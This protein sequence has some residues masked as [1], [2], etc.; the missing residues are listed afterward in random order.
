MLNSIEFSP[1]VTRLRYNSI[2]RWVQVPRA[3]ACATTI[4]SRNARAQIQAPARA[5]GQAARPSAWSE[6]PISKGR[7]AHAGPLG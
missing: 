7:R 1:C 6:N 4:P 3:A 5:T 2:C